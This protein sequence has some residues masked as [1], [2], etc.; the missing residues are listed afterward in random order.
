MFD[1]LLLCSLFI[2]Q[3]PLI[4]VMPLRRKIAGNC[5]HFKLGKLVE[6]NIYQYLC[7]GF[8]PEFNNLNVHQHE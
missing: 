4:Y 8:T 7:Q 5:K 1:I 3:I 2:R 6:L